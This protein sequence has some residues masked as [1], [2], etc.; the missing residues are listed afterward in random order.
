MISNITGSKEQSWTFWGQDEEHVRLPIPL[1]GCTL[2]SL[3][4][5]CMARADGQSQEPGIALSPGIVR[6][7]AELVTH[8][9]QWSGFPSLCTTDSTGPWQRNKQEGLR[10][11]LRLKGTQKS[12]Q[13][14]STSSQRDAEPSHLRH[15]VSPTGCGQN[16]GMKTSREE[17][18]RFPCP[19]AGLRDPYFLR[20]PQFKTTPT[21]WSHIL[22]MV[23]NF[24]H[25]RP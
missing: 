6:G 11:E 4:T 13:S 24:P 3:W 23:I 15:V 25:Q 21:I 10:G 14:R 16:L 22:Q 9:S 19:Q 20:W 7:N 8:Q 5:H 2:L 12:W 18:Q 17:E 1:C